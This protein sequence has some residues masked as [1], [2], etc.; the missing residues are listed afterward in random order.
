VW[1]PQAVGNT[2]C[3]AEQLLAQPGLASKKNTAKY[4]IKYFSGYFILK[5]V[6]TLKYIQKFIGFIFVTL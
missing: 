5:V 1:R 4:T 2:A 3:P 6:Q